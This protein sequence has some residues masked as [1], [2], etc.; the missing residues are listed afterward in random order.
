MSLRYKGA[1]ISATA[2]V[3][4]GGEDGTA[5]GAWTLEQQ[6][7]LQAAGLWPAQPTPKY[8][9]DVFSTYLYTGNGSTQTITN[10]ID[11]AGK[12][13]MVWAK[14]RA[15]GSHFLYDTVR[16]VNKYLRSNATDSQITQADSLTAF[17]T[18]GFSIGNAIF[19]DNAVNYAS[20][21][22]R[23]QPKFFDVVTYTGN[24]VAGRTVAHGLGSAPG[25]III[26]STSLAVNW[27][28]YHRSTGNTDGLILNLT[29]A[30]QAVN[31]WN[32]TTPA[33]T[34]FTL[35]GGTGNNAG[36]TY[37]AYLFA[38]DA[39]GF[40]PAFT[41]N[42]I[43]CGSF[44]ADGASQATVTLGYE[45]QWLLVKPSS[46]GGGS[47]LLVDNMRGLNANLGDQMLRPNS[48][49]AESALGFFK[50]NATGFTW[51]GADP[52]TAYIY[53]AIRRGPMKVPTDGTTV[54][55]V[56]TLTPT[57]DLIGTKVTNPF[58]TDL[59]ITTQ[60]SHA[61]LPSTYAVDR[62]RGGSQSVATNSP[63]AEQDWGTTYSW[64]FDYNNGFLDNFAYPQGSVTTPMIYWSFKRAPGFFD[65]V[66]YAGTGVATTVAH[67]L[68][69][70]P[71]LM[72]VKCRSTATNDWIVYAGSLG[73]NSN[74]YLNY[75]YQFDTPSSIWNTTT[76]TASVFSIGGTGLQV[77]NSGRTYVAYLFATCPGVSK[78]GSYTGTGA[79]LTIDCGFAAGARFVLI[80]RTNGSGGWYV[81]DTAR[82]MVSGTDPSL[83]LNSTAAEVNANSIYTATTGFQIVST[84]AGI[85]ASGGSYIF[86]AIA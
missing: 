44:T 65:E 35:G 79:T 39:G 64:K 73:N 55:D 9:E 20:W 4:T 16:G 56:D 11:L 81:W 33:T 72:I 57:A 58:A 45:P 19:N 61:G 3:T 29:A 46:G 82:G 10:G 22:F 50:I 12:G 42:V 49:A 51:S 26:K 76:P 37:V 34:E 84:A 47:W 1:T 70:V 40:G 7:Q 38:H 74:G 62:L 69:V 14:S 8:I 2:P 67:N 27:Q 21:T 71:E 43:S 30:T 48:S 86:L 63:N 68:A 52:S 85:N 23:E 54:F 36:E 17:N 13:G 28:V 78:V 32:N 80:K 24:G 53:I 66:C 59:L 18:T 15:A 5:P 60:R 75:T 77:N 6:S 25:C 83:L 41:D 31:W